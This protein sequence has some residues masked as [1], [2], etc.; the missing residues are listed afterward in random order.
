[1]ADVR[2]SPIAG[3]WYPGSAQALAESVDRYLAQAVAEGL[4]KFRL[5]HPIGEGARTPIR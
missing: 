1:M 2:P 5:D 4:I 3:L